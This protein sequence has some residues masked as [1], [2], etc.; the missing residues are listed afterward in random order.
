MLSRPNDRSL[1]TDATDRSLGPGFGDAFIRL[2]PEEVNR[3][4]IE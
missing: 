4:G 2:H 3:F 1:H